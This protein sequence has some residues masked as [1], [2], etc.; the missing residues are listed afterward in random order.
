M[1]KWLLIIPLFLIIVIWQATYIYLESM[2]Y[3]K[4]GEQTAITYAKK[5]TNISQV[6]DVEYYHGKMAYFAVYGKS[7]HNED[8]I[9]WVPEDKDGKM[10]TRLAKQGWSKEK[11][12]SHVMDSQNPLKII[13]I[14]LG[15]EVMKDNRTEEI[16]TTPLWE[17]TYIDQQNR[18]TYY[19]IK[20]IDGSFV[21]RYSL[22][23]DRF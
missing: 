21:K 4:K 18:H 6:T 8:M 20:F 7:N 16:E 9:V 3:Q 12:R 17:V 11:V 5:N 22:K 14:R 1:K 13:D 10:I 23:K 19:F 15:A 2:S